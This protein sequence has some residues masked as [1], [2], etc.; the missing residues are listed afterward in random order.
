MANNKK[1]TK[2]CCRVND[3]MKTIVVTLVICLTVVVMFYFMF[4]TPRGVTIKQLEPCSLNQLTIGQTYEIH[5]NT[6]I[7][8]DMTN[9]VDDVRL[10]FS[11]VVKVAEEEE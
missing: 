10:Y 6:M 2:E 11:Q 3:T 5:G 9:Y 4:V 8:K 7:L 1:E